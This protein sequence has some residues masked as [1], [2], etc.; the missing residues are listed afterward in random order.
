MSL[1]IAVVLLHTR[2]IVASGALEAGMWFGVLEILTAVTAD[3]LHMYHQSAD[4][5]EQ[6]IKLGMVHHLPPVVVLLQ[7]QVVAPAL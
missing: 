5:L 1:S 3:V 4:F 7:L 6:V 2:L